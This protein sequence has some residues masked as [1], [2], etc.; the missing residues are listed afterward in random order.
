M[1]VFPEPITYQYNQK[2]KLLFKF[3]EVAVVLQLARWVYANIMHQSSWNN[4]SE[5]APHGHV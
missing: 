2:F 1:V 5:H 3:S 4:N